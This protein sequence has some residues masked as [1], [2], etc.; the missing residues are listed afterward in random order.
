MNPC[1]SRSRRAGSNRGDH[2][3]GCECFDERVGVVGEDAD[4]RPA[5]FGFARSDK[6]GADLVETFDEFGRKLLDVGFDRGDSGFF[7]DRAPAV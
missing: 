5:R 3:V 4:K 1:K 6:G 2:V 7:D